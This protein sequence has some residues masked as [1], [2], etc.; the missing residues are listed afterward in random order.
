MIPTMILF[1]LVFG[2]WWKSA[3]VAAALVWP[4]ILLVNGV[5]QPPWIPLAATLVLAAALSVANAGVGVALHQAL[6]WF[7]RLLRHPA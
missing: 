3:L 6:L 4:V 2:R 7:V 5:L 1:G